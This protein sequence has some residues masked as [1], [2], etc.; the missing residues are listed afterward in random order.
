MFLIITKQMND[1][2]GDFIC[3]NLVGLVGNAPTTS[4]MSSEHSTIEL[5]VP[6]KDQYIRI[7]IKTLGANTLLNLSHYAF[8]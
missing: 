5:T 2:L 4:R 7:K 3:N 6:T 8:K 1:I